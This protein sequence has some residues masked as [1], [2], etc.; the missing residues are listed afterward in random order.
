MYVGQRFSRQLSAPLLVAPVTCGG[1]PIVHAQATVEGP[2]AEGAAFVYHTDHNRGLI[3]GYADGTFRPGNDVVRA[4][5][6]KMLSLG[7]QCQ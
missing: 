3:S 4:H 2:G 1:S 5:T 7:I 6:A